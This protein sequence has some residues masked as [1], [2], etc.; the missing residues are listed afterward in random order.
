MKM[1]SAGLLALSNAKDF[2][3]V[4]GQLVKRHSAFEDCHIA[5]E[6]AGQLFLFNQV[7]RAG[8]VQ[9]PS[10][11]YLL[12]LPF[13]TGDTVRKPDVSFVSFQRLPVTDKIPTGYPLVAPDLAVEVISPNDLA[14]EVEAKIKDY[15]QA[16]VRLVWIINP[17][18]KSVQIYRQDGTSARLLE[19]DEIN[20]E[21]VLPEFR[22]SIS[23]LLEI[24]QS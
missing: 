19:S 18:S 15:L 7:H 12:S 13:R 5:G 9:G 1:A 22:S 3:L 16:G 23:S 10:C 4:D 6:L 17:S 11:G 20:G 14:Y 2:E 21:D 8:W 24:P